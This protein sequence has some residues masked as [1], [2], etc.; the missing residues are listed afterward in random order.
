M[1]VLLL[2]SGRLPGADIP[3]VPDALTLAVAGVRTVVAIPGQFGSGPATQAVYGSDAAS[4]A[5]GITLLLAVQAPAGWHLL[6]VEQPQATCRFDTGETAAS[7][8]ATPIPDLLLRQSLADFVALVVHTTKPQ[9]AAP[10][11]TFALGIP[12]PAHPAH[13]LVVLT[14]TVRVVLGADASCARATLVLPDHGARPLPGQNGAIQVTTDG[15][16]LSM[17]CAAGTRPLGISDIR[18]QDAAGTAETSTSCESSVVDQQRLSFDMVMP[19]PTARLDVG[20][21][22][23]RRTGTL[24]F[25]LTD[26]PLSSPWP[27]PRTLP[28]R[29]AAPPIASTITVDPPPSPPASPAAKRSF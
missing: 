22:T 18:I 2:G 5:P 7:R 16:T 19:R 11:T 3:A 12:L 10:W 6:T 27:A 1:L 9:P 23:Q 14:G 24:T 25:Q 4:W 17:T 15:L 29:W 13:T 26:L 21:Y 8:D 28:V 20:L